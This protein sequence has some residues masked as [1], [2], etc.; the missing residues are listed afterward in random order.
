MK[1][2]ILKGKYLIVA[3]SL[4]ILSTLSSGA[5]DQPAAK[6]NIGDRAP[7]LKYGQWL[8]GTPINEYETGRLYIMEFWATWCGPC[9]MVMPHLSKLARDRKDNVTVIG[10]NIFEGSHESEPKPYD[11]YLPKVSRFITSM[12]DNMDYNVIIDNNDEF[13]AKNW[14]IAAGQNG[15]PC[16]FLVRDSTILWIGHPVQLDSIIQVV[17]DGKYDIGQEL[18]RKQ[19]IS[20]R[21][22]NSH[23]AL[24]QLV[25]SEFEETLKA[26]KVEEAMAIIDREIEELYTWAYAESFF[27]FQALLEHTGEKQAFEFLNQWYTRK[28]TFRLSVAGLIASKQGLAKSSYEKALEILREEII[29]QPDLTPILQSMTAQIY[30]N[31]GDFRKAVKTQETALK[32]VEQAVKENKLPGVYLDTTI[33]E[34]KEQLDSYR[35]KGK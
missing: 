23:S 3:F 35:Q 9:K 2:M 7:E 28:P 30:A 29:K 24:A 5:Q 15:I 4:I 34:Y 19:E 1:N 32:G 14:M 22:R 20:A 25:L 16:S 6:L 18:K 11:S 31:M 8:K 26:G 21:S 33:E 12:G 27:K 10:V 13:M 17:L